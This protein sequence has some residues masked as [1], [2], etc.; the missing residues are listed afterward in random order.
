M[1]RGEHVPR[2]EGGDGGVMVGVGVL[3]GGTGG[4]WKVVLCSMRARREGK[5]DLGLEGHEVEQQQKMS[6]VIQSLWLTRW[7]VWAWSGEFKW[8]MRV[9][10]HVKGVPVPDEEWGHP[11]MGHE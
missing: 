11:R 8:R 10:L 5:K 7:C 6:A 1:A 2:V 9:F 3:R 4:G